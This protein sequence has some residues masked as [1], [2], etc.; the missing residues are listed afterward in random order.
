MENCELSPIGSMETKPKYG[1]NSGDYQRFSYRCEAA[2]VRK[3]RCLLKRVGIGGRGV[4]RNR[5]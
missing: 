1:D 5:F 3:F 4:A 2:I